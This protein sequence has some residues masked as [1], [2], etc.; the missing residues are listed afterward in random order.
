MTWFLSACFS[1]A[2]AETTIELPLPGQSGQVSPAVESSSL[3]VPSLVELAVAM[4]LIVK[5]GP[6][7]LVA[8]T[9]WTV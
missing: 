1:I 2:S 5:P 9:M 8:E 3:T 7:A 4:F 6:A